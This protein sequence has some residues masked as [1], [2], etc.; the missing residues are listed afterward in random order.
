[1]RLSV[2]SVVQVLGLLVVAAVLTLTA[3]LSWIQLA[4]RRVPAGQA[5]LVTLAADSLPEF[6]R[7]FN[8]AEGEV[9]VLALL[10][11]T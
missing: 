7:A 8:A 9:R 2:R 6:R 11:P 4:P 3:G 10:S 1:M 5:A